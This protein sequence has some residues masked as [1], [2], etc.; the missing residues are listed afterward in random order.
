MIEEGLLAC[1]QWGLIA[2]RPAD[3]CGFAPLR[4]D[5]HKLY[6]LFQ[7]IQIRESESGDF[8][9]SLGILIRC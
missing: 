1:C 4:A 5:A 7:G 8:R 9:D 3:V 2:H 6:D